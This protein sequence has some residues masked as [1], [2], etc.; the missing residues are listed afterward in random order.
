MARAGENANERLIRLVKEF[1][2]KVLTDP[3]NES[4]H[5]H[6]EINGTG[7]LIYNNPYN[8]AQVILSFRTFKELEDFLTSSPIVQLAAAAKSGQRL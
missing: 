6:L 7:H 2:Q 3:E 8:F 4:I 5:I 1:S